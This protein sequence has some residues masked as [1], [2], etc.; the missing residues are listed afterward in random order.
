[1]VVLAITNGIKRNNLKWKS[2][3]GEHNT[4]QGTHLLQ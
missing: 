4:E 3:I 1:M 2:I